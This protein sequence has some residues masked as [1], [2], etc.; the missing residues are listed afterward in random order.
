M[1]RMTHP[2]YCYAEQWLCFARRHEGT[3]DGRR[4]HLDAGEVNVRIPGPQLVV[5][6][7]HNMYTSV[8]GTPTLDT[9]YAGNII[10]SWAQ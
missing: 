2:N 3:V 10:C 7:N 6:K 9:R 5:L 1:L 4:S 8:T